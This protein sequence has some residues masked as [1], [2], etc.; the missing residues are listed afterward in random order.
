M[1][2]LDAYRLADEIT[3]GDVVVVGSGVAGLTAA[4]GL[5]PRRVTV[6]T[7]A[8]LGGGSSS[9]WAQGG[10]AAAM[11]TDDSPHLHA[12]DTLAAGAGLG[13]PGVIEA[14]THEGPERIRRLIER[15]ARF[16][17]G[18]GGELALGREGAHGRRRILHAGGDATGVE[19][20]RALVAE[21][22]RHPGVRLHEQA[23]VHDLVLAEGRVV[24]VL[25]RHGSGAR[26][27]TVLHRATAVVLATGGFGQLY[28]RTTNPREATGDGLALAARAGAQLADLELVQFHPTA[29]E[30]TDDLVSM[31][32]LPLVTE[33]LRGEGA[34]LIDDLGERFMEGIHPLAELGPRDVVARAIRA[35]Q[36]AGHRVFLDAREAVGDTFPRRFP[37]VWSSCQS[38]GVDP[39]SQPIPVT[40]AAHYVMAGIAVDGSGRSTLPGLWA[41]GEV[42]S[43]G[44]HGANRLA[45][46][47]L[48]EALVFGARVA[49]DLGGVTQP[50]KIPRQAVESVVWREEVGAEGSDNRRLREAIRRL[51]WEHA[52]LERDGI[53]LQQ[54]LE[55]LSE[56]AA[57]LTPEPS[58]AGNLWTV[59]RLV[60]AAAWAREESRGS[61]YRTDFPHSMERYARRHFWTYDPHA[62]GDDFPLVEAH[63]SQLTQE[64]A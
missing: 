34:I 10:V 35:R 36:Q 6:L 33:A 38:L 63:R 32:P 47:S 60:T 40:P 9:G 48:L 58:E 57:G 43:T 3:G 44:V 22:R 56:Q 55:G 39:R 45:S 46:N 31:E 51:M 7:K 42:T 20:V 49:D 16:D 1:K 8:T 13:D 37:T 53:G 61:H 11:S 26:A 64:I 54:A 29:L 23:F 12:A 4:L 19:M 28:A 24:G 5:L 25:A 14:L 17:R 2:A 62:T 41:C 30:V 52:S 59:G 15:G 27:R 18:P 21:V 50:R